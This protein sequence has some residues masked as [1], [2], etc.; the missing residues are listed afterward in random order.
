MPY[1]I[2]PANLSAVF[3]VP[4]SVVDKHL[5]LAGETQL[6]VLLY[7]L[8]NMASGLDVSAAAGA[9]ALPESDVNDAF[10]YWTQAGILLNDTPQ[11]PE[12]QPPVHI[13]V[14]RAERPTRTDVA[15]RGNEDPK[16]M[17]LLREAQLKFGRN[18]KTNESASLVWLYD[19]EG[20]EVS[21]ILMLLQYAASEGRCNISFI[22][23]TAVE[24]ISSGVQ[25]VADAE[26]QIAESARKKTAW[27]LVQAVF[28]FDRRQPSVKELEF[29]DKWMNEWGISREL[30]KCAYDACVD[31]KAKISMPYIGKILESWHKKGI[32]SPDELQKAAVEKPAQSRNSLA[33]YDIDLFEKMLNSDE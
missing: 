4:C 2:N 13:A 5:K 17:F 14:P 21:V 20:M 27:N 12:A 7:V 15:C 19:D 23:K 3:T 28:C 9:L 16:I 26:K 22:E 25:N 11:Q 10:L 8:R 32:K 30:L 31:S 18:L 1:Y 33:A 24:W 29:S 6:K